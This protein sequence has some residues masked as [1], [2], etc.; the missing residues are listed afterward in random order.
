VKKVIQN[1][2]LNEDNKNK[3]FEINNFDDL[4]FEHRNREYGA[5]QLRRKYFRVLLGGVIFSA[6]IGILA[7]LIPFL[8]RPREDRILSGGGGY[9]VSVRMENL[10]TPPDQI[11]VPPAPPPPESSKVP[12]TVQYVPPVVVDTLL[13]TDVKPATTD[14]ALASQENAIPDG[15]GSGFGDS[16]IP[17]GDGSGSEEPL[18]L[19]EV[20]PTFKGGDL[21][22]FREWVEKRTNYPAAA[23]ENK[24]RGTVFLT[25]IVEKD[26]SVSNVTV[27]KGVHPLLDEEAVKAISDSP[28]WSPGLQR[29]QPVRVRFQIP[30]TFQY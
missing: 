19:V 24:I 7:V 6:T 27:L 18:F 15:T 11:Y 5:Y 17:G 8:A 3:P 23:L 20:M 9:S 28:K 1:K 13:S 22:K 12:E 29:G 4:V 16:L 14:M 26:G 10:T 21:T 2:T 25:F 30:L